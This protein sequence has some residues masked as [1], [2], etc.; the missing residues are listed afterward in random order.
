MYLSLQ[1]KCFVEFYRRRHSMYPL[2]Y[3]L[4]YLASWLLYV[5]GIIFH[6]LIYSSPNA[7]MTNLPI[8]SISNALKSLKG[9][10]IPVN[11]STGS[12]T[13]ST[14]TMKF[15]FPGF[16][17][18]ISTVAAHPLSERYATILLALLLNMPHLQQYEKECRI[19]ERYNMQINKT[20]YENVRR[21]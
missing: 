13:P 15:P 10:F 4:A 16:V 21:K 6:P 1:Q 14:R 9:R 20:N 8:S 2:W 3:S 17:L 7:S 19:W 18:L 12:S 11:S 5:V